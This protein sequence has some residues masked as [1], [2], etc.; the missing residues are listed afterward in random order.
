ML[1]RST[2]LLRSVAL[3]RAPILQ[4]TTLPKR[5]ASSGPHFNEPSGYL[6]GEKVCLSYPLELVV[7]RLTAVAIASWT[8]EKVGELGVGFDGNV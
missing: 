8:E 1:P 5:F 6:F 2:P 4:S 7:S 3:V